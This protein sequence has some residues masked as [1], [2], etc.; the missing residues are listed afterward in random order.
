M[1][2]QVRKGSFANRDSARASPQAPPRHSEKLQKFDGDKTQ[3]DSE[4]QE[5]TDKIV[6]IMIICIYIINIVL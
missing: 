5:D 3:M 4:S 1:G 2:R 6:S